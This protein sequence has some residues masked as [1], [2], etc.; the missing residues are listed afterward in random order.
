MTENRPFRFGIVLGGIMAHQ[1][2][3]VLARRIEDD[4]FSTLQ[5]ADH[6]F[7]GFSP[8]LSLLSAAEATQRL[9]VGSFVLSNDFRYPAVL[10]KEIATFDVMTEGR[11]ELGMGA[12]WHPGEYQQAG[13]PFESP[14]IR[15]AR[16]AESI[17]ILKGLLS[18]RDGEPFTFQGD[19]YAIQGL[20][21]RPTPVQIPHPPILIGGAGKH[22]LSLAAREADIV[23]I[24]MNLGGERK[25]FADM[26][27]ARLTQR[28]GWIREA[29]GERFAQLELNLL[30]QKV[31]ITDDP[32][33]I[34]TRFIE[35][36]GWSEKT[37]R[38][39]QF[40]S[41][42]GWSDLTPEQLLASPYYLIG[43]LDQIIEKVYMLREQYGIS[44]F[45][46]FQEAHDAMKTVVAQL[47]GR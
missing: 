36:Q 46:I 18:S 39:D 24:N 34:V 19:H 27:P 16:L 23:G 2:W 32:T 10:A 26:S 5:V 20:I 31:I 3:Q 29:A 45:S 6:F 25:N 8:F 40:S 35:N 28:L 12:G 33:S 38:R 42:S 13:I 14:A 22:L 7:S 11:F 37:V 17:R 47:A 21:E 9:R 43:S 30:L 15:V 44:Y 1:Q 41:V 4:G